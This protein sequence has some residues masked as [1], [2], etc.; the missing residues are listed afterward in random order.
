MELP[1]ELLE[2]HVKWVPCHNGK[3]R[4]QVADGA[5]GFQIW[6]V[7]VNIL[8]K[9]SRT[10]ESWWSSRLEVRRGANNAAYQLLNNYG[11]GSLRSHQSLSYPR[12]F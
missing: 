11:A 6:R 1:C 8:N 2:T 7:A 12:I 9:Q 4:P 3:A 10:A 5:D